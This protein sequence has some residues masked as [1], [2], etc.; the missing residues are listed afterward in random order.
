MKDKDKK[1]EVVKE[2]LQ[3]KFELVGALEC[4]LADSK[5]EHEHLLSKLAKLHA[6]FVKANS[7]CKVLPLLMLAKSAH[8]TAQQ[9]EGMS[10]SGCQS[11]SC[12]AAA[13]VSHVKKQACSHQ[14]CNHC[15]AWK[16]LLHHID[17]CLFRQLAAFEL[18]TLDH[19]SWAA[20]TIACWHVVQWHVPWSCSASN[21]QI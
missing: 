17:S 8:R 2:Q 20:L 11:S 21:L 13:M 9:R 19:E 1:M 6:Q 12:H 10:L 16:V 7:K 14:I 18:H 5:E 4:K 15:T 3:Q